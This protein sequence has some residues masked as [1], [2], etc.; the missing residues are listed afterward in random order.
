MHTLIVHDRNGEIKW[1]AVQDSEIDGELEIE[2]DN[3]ESVLV[4]DMGDV[5]IEPQLRSQHVQQRAND[6]IREFRVDVARG[7]LVRRDKESAE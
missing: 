2:V 4:F 3:G 1:L 7:R 6:M 5:G